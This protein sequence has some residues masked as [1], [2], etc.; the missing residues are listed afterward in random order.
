[1]L[2]QPYAHL[3]SSLQ[4]FMPTVAE[5]IEF[6]A[7]NAVSTKA[8]LE[9][10][11][12]VALVAAM[13]EQ[14]DAADHAAAA[15]TSVATSA[16]PAV[17][18]SVAVGSAPAVDPL[19]H[20]AV[21]PSI[22]RDAAILSAEAGAGKHTAPT[23]P[24]LPTP[25]V[26]PPAFDIDAK[27]PAGDRL[28]FDTMLN[29][30]LDAFALSSV[31][32]PP[33][34][35]GVKHAIHLQE[36]KEQPIKMKPYRNSDS[37]KIYID[38]N[39]VKLLQYNLI[40]L[41]N[42]PWSA[43]IVI[44]YKHDGSPRM[45]IDYRR[46]NSVTRKDAYP[47]PLIEE[48]LNMC[49]DADFLSTIDVQDAYYHIEMEES[50]KPLTAFVTSQ[51]LFEWNVMPF[52]L[53]NA[54]ATFQRHVDTVLRPVLGKTCSAFFDDIVVFTKGTIQD[55]IRDTQAVLAL[56]ATAHLSAKVKKCKFGYKEIIFLGHLIKEGKLYP[57]PSK[58][59]AIQRFPVPTDLTTLK[60]FLGIANYYR[61]FIPHFVRL[62]K[63]LYALQKKDVQWHWDAAEADSLAALK[64]AL[65]DPRCLHAPDARRP[66]ILHTDA[67]YDGLG[68]VLVQV[69]ADGQ[70]HP[71]GFIST[72]LDSAQKN[73]T[74]S[75]LECLAVVWAVDEFEPFLIDKHFT[76]I[77]DHEA[78]VWLPSKNFANKRLLRW[79]MR[80]GQ[81]HYTVKHR[82][83]RNNA[84]ADGL[85]RSPLLDTAAADS[86]LLPALPPLITAVRAVPSGFMPRHINA[87]HL[88]N[89]PFAPVT[90]LAP[91]TRR[92]EKRAAPPSA[93]AAP[94]P[95]PVASAAPPAAVRAAKNA[96]LQLVELIDS[97]FYDKIIA[98]QHADPTLLPLINYL[99]RST[100]PINY[101]PLERARLISKSKLYFLNRDT[102]QPGLYQI[103]TRSRGHDLPSTLVAN[104]PR[105][106]V[107]ASFHSTLL[108]MYHDSPFGGHLGVT[109]TYRKLSV[110]YYW[111][112]MFSAVDSYVGACHVCQTEKARRHDIKHLTLRMENPTR[113]FN[114]MSMDFIGPLTR[115]HDFTY[116]LTFIDHFTKFAIAIPCIKQDSRTAAYVFVNEVVCRY[117]APEVLL[118][119][120]G[121]PFDNAM[122]AEVYKM[123]RVQKQFS[124]AYHPQANGQIERFNG[125]LKQILRALCE[126]DPDHWVGLLQ[127]AVF[128]YNTSVHEATGVSPFYALFGR[129]ARA[130]FF[131]S[132]PDFDHA[133]AAPREVYAAR[134]KSDLERAS[135]WI[136]SVYKKKTA[137]QHAANLKLERIPV[138]ELNDLVYLRDPSKISY[139][140]GPTSKVANYLPYPFRVLARTGDVIYTVRALDRST[141]LLFGK[142][143]KTHVS[144]MKRYR[145]QTA[146]ELKAMEPL[147]DLDPAQTVSVHYREPDTQH[148]H[149]LPVGDSDVAQ[150]P[151]FAPTSGATPRIPAPRTNIK[152]PDSSEL[153]AEDPTRANETTLPLPA[154]DPLE[155]SVAQRALTNR[156]STP[157]APG[158]LNEEA[159]AYSP[160]ADHQRFYSLPPRVTPNVD[161]PRR[162]KAT[163]GADTPSVHVKRQR[164]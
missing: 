96:P 70:E 75:E 134:L 7:S 40:R 128:A 115:S 35:L 29:S 97:S 142:T 80:L 18:S 98:A 125:T 143:F 92:R 16:S 71:C 47:M 56:L 84:N 4:Y 74:I 153:L 156:R 145:E 30:Q 144:I 132:H 58:L 64:A 68:A 105:L 69:G 106:V 108:E 150:A 10:A 45:C 50:S 59:A 34:T 157:L 113:P 120:N 13:K 17:V 8:A 126:M 19:P 66:F 123:L 152:L 127:P 137:D 164:R 82:K 31:G 25:P 77:T 148:L 36:G 114:I 163:G 130:P 42:S 140:T 81:Y 49:K 73:Y 57:D 109:H 11:A 111:E 89:T 65:L 26:G 104:T 141:G 46:L 93:A 20:S 1:M 116:V 63:P 67:S 62:A 85:S 155:D 94:P 28:R 151:V 78:L 88:T 117:G 86:N 37:K 154:D 9:Y 48:C 99:E 102:V 44:V 162:K 24:S 72:Q 38:E 110:M 23:P 139:K 76:V 91:V 146:A 60:S 6:R 33:P 39:V 2:G 158:A 121:S 15:D 87:A 119:D 147:V 52:G 149:T 135:E 54:P 51:G 112:Q 14:T 107:P 61:R 22:A 55:H 129:E 133:G 32:P 79:A 131:P 27:L 100:V 12:T 3:V 160:A 5:A 136:D 95:P 53:S 124:T 122:A 103:N 161:P 90:L 83:G 21:D 118:S 159:L 41:S 43:P 138:F 101:P